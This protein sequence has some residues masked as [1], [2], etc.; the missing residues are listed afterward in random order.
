MLRLHWLLPAVHPLESSLGI[1]AR[2]SW[3]V[4]N[5][6]AAMLAFVQVCNHMSFSGHFR[7]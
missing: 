3:K 7:F 1:M 6:V 4:L 5:V 2:S